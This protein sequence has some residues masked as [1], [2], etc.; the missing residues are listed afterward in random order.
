MTSGLNFIFPL[1]IA[2]RCSSLEHGPDLER[3][4][5][6]PAILVTVTVVMMHLVQVAGMQLCPTPRPCTP[7]RLDALPNEIVRVSMPCASSSNRMAR[8][9]RCREKF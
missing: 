6:C 9:L 1:H 2:R 7:T 3:S 8:E 5:N 4:V